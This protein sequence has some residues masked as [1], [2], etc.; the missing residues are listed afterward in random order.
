MRIEPAPYVYWNDDRRVRFDDRRIAGE[1]RRAEQASV[2]RA[3]HGAHMWFAPAFGA[4]ILGQMVPETV[5]PAR[6]RR[7]YAQTEARTPLRPRVVKSA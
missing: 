3:R 7:A 5:I 2:P 6:A 4:Q 1:D